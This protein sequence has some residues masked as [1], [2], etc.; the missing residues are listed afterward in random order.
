MITT[1]IYYGKKCLNIL[2]FPK[3]P[4]SKPSVFTFSEWVKCV[5][6]QLEDAIPH[7]TVVEGGRTSTSLQS[8]LSLSR[9]TKDA[10]SSQEK[11][12]SVLS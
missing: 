8:W 2:C 10:V 7:E 3:T 4:K 12:A 11:K 1:Q 6:H 5:Y 9:E